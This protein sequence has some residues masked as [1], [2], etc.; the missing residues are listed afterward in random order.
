MN[1]SSVEG[2]TWG[3]RCYIAQEEERQ[4]KIKSKMEII[5]SKGSDKDQVEINKPISE[6]AIIE[7]L[8]I[9]KKYEYSIVD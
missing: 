5:I 6:E 2:I 8:K 9:M 7:F 4:R 1:I 3:G